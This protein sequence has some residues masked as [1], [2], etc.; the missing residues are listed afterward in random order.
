M[1]RQT[2]SPKEAVRALLAGFTDCV[3]GGVDQHVSAYLQAI[4]WDKAS[5]RKQIAPN[6]ELVS[7]AGLLASWGLKQHQYWYVSH[8][9]LLQAY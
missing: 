5:W 1:M 6:H 8:I 9:I 7:K 2:A 3:N 4:S